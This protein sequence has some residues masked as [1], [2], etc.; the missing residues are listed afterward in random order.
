M[1]WL[2]NMYSDFIDKTQFPSLVCYQKS[3]ISIF[4]SKLLE[5]MVKCLGSELNPPTKKSRN[6]WNYLETIGAKYLQHLRTD[7]SK[8]SRFSG[9]KK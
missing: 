7:N 3:I 8:R 2:M 1:N 9:N 5:N 4:F 6:Y